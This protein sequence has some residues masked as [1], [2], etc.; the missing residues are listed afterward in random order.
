MGYLVELPPVTSGSFG[1]L[2][3]SYVIIET[4]VSYED[5]NSHKDLHVAFIFI[6]WERRNLSLLS[7]IAGTLP[8]IPSPVKSM[9]NFNRTLLHAGTL[10]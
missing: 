9:R 6:S 7:R 8:Y 4:E 5:G 10:E 2:V 3:F 1:S